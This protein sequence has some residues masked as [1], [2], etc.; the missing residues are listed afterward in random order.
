VREVSVSVRGERSEKKRYKGERKRP[1]VLP[2]G[3]FENNSSSN[4]LNILRNTSSPNSLHEKMNVRS[5]K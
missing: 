4:S 2:F 5:E 1:L 3:D